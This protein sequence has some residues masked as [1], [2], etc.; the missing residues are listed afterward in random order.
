MVLK[1]ILN[2][3]KE[4]D[5]FKNDIKFYKRVCCNSFSNIQWLN[6]DYLMDKPK[7][8]FTR[9]L[10]VFNLF[11]YFSYPSMCYIYRY[12]NKLVNRLSKGGVG[13]EQKTYHLYKLEW[14]MT[15]IT[16]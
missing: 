4:F 3:I 1:M 6:D 2:F 16:F 11:T 14:T 7:R 13:I 15:L 9:F 5:G 12:Q 8:L 10:L